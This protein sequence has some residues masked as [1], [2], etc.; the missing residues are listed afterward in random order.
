MKKIISSYSNIFDIYIHFR[1]S[2]LLDFQ[3]Y[4]FF[5]FDFKV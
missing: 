1:F 4:I 3:I 2:I 5:I